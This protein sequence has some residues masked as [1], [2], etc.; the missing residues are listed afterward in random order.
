MELDIRG[1]ISLRQLIAKLG[2][3]EDSVGV[4][5]VNKKWAMFDSVVRDGDFVQLYPFMEGG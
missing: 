4:L 2:L 5:L 1:A 3:E